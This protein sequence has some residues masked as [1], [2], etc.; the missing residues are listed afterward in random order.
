MPSYL[1]VETFQALLPL[2]LGF[3]G[4]CMIWI[5]CAEL[6]PDALQAASHPSVATAVT[7][8]AAW[9]VRS[10]ACGGWPPEG[11]AHAPQGLRQV[12]TL[13]LWVQTLWCVVHSRH[14]GQRV[15]AGS[16]THFKHQ[17]LER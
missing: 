16:R 3:A 9:C 10:A 14:S 5:V 2:A 6:L 1:F 11:T 15:P 13:C 17:A 4:G 7:F 12:S 8:S